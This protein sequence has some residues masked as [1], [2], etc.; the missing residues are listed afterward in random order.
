MDP[1]ALLIIHS[2]YRWIVLFSMLVQMIW[3]LYHRNSNTVFR[4]QHLCLMILF[5]L[6]YDIQLFIGALLYI[7]SP[8]VKTFLADIST[9]IH[10]RQLRFFGMEHIAMMSLA[11]LLFNGITLFCIKKTGQNNVFHFIF[12][13]HLWIYIMIITSIPWSFSP[14]TNRPNFR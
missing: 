4:R 3:V 11:I 2:Y 10:Q 1:A 7:Q 9:G 14:L 8:L 12:K 13:W 6:I 5:S